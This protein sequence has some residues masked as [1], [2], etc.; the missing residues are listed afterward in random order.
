MINPDYGLITNF[1]KAHLEGFGSIEGVVNALFDIRMAV[2]NQERAILLEKVLKNWQ[3]NGAKIV[4]TRHNYLPHSQ[5]PERFET[6]YEVI[7]KTVDAVIH[8][9]AYSIKEY[10]IRY[11]GLL[12]K[13]VMFF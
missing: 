4:I 7:Y 13:T 5:N 6:L 11:D 12:P 10:K 3:E 2:Q 9:G 1:G 8:L